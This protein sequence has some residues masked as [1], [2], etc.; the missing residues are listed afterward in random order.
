M[1]AVSGGGIAGLAAGI[2]VLRNQVPLLFVA[3]PTR[4]THAMLGGIQ[5]APN[6]WDALDH[7]GVGDLVR[8]K[9]TNLDAIK[10]RDMRS[11]VTLASLDLKQSAYAS[12]ARASLTQVLEAEIQKIGLE[13]QTRSPIRLCFLCRSC[14]SIK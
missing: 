3:G 10:V 6:G 5:I 7:L 12:I 4:P 1:I 11:A 14:L 8:A 13:G 9:A 2:A